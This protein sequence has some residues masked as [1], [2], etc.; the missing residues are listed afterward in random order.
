MKKYLFI[1]ICMSTSAAFAQLAVQSSGLTVIAGTTINIDNLVLTPSANLTIANQTI[2]QSVTPSPGVPSGA[3]ILQVHK[4][5]SPIT[6]SG[7]AAIKYNAVQLN[8]NTE[9]SLQIA[10]NPSIASGAFVTTSGS[11]TGA[12]GSYYVS[13]SGFSNVIF[14]QLTAT[15]STGVLPLSLLSFKAEASVNCSV[16]IN[17]TAAATSDHENFIVETSANNMDWQAVRIPIVSVTGN[18]TYT[19]TDED[20]NA[21]LIYYRLKMISATGTV[22]YSN[23][24]P[25][26]LTCVPKLM[27]NLSP[28]PVH[29]IAVLKVQNGILTKALIAIKDA[30]GKTVK[31]VVFSGSVLSLDMAAFSKGIYVISCKTD[32]ESYTWRIVLQ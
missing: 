11:T 4:F 30:S 15:S 9:A 23:T 17:W 22:S 18:S 12:A 3:S 32:T 7:T 25:V 5:S 19:F 2:T 1:L 16:K 6:F 13:K 27:L 20:P 10:Y 31:T 14:G 26:R 29:D 8:G 24:I 28:N 21:G